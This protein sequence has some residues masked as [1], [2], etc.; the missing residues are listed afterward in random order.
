MKRRT[1]SGV[2]LPA[3]A[4]ARSPALAPPRF[5]DAGGYVVTAD[6][7]IGLASA[8]QF[9]DDSGNLGRRLGAEMEVGGWLQASTAA[10]ALK[11]LPRGDRAL[12][13]A[14][15]ASMT[16]QALRRSI[17]ADGCGRRPG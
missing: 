15:F 11:M 13:E 14:E 17:D 10:G 5:G 16:R 4:P 6:S 3:P 8:R 9:D 12:A 1:T 2:Y 7:V